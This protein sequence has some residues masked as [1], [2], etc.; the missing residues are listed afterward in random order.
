MTD[1]KTRLA[2][3]SERGTHAGAEELR[4]RVMLDLAGAGNPARPATPGWAIAL[5]GAAIAVI[6]IG[7]PLIMLRRTAESEPAGPI[8]TA[9]ATPTTVATTPAAAES[10]SRGLVSGEAVNPWKTTEVTEPWACDVVDVAA[11]P[12]GGFAVATRYEGGVF[13]SGDGDSWQ[14]ANPDGLASLPVWPDDDNLRVITAL[15]GRVAVLD[16]RA[17]VVWLGDL[18]TGQWQPVTL[19]WENTVPFFDRMV[20]TSSHEEI[21]VA[22][23][24]GDNDELAGHTLVWLIDPNTGQVDRVALPPEFAKSTSADTWSRNGLEAARFGNRWVL[25]AGDSTA[26]SLDGL[27]W[28]INHDEDGLASG[29]RGVASLTAGSNGLIATTCEW[30]HRSWLSKD[31]LEWT[32]APAVPAHHYGFAYSDTLGFVVVSERVFTSADG[33]AW[34]WTLGPQL[35][36]NIIDTAAS[37]DNVFILTKTHSVAAV[38]YI[39]TLDQTGN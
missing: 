32:E 36:D 24:Y 12:E 28:A 27:T 14:D 13:W 35:E 29:D 37:G 6:L 10:D 34:E 4:Q 17:P 39:M 31:G 20:I 26:V 5:A 15:P 18:I 38:P 11:L 9:P 16:S 1:L 23:R 25:A 22:G 8:T 33:R 19:D 21:L 7:A 3:L 2:E 30:A